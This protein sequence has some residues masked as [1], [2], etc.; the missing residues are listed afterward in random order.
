MPPVIAN[1]LRRITTWMVIYGAVKAFFWWGIAAYAWWKYRRWGRV[2][3]VL[4]ASD[5]GLILS[6]PGWRR[7]SERRWSIREIK[8]IELHPVWGNLKWKRTVADLY[9][10][11]HRGRRLR[12]RLSSPDPHLPSRIANQLKLK[13]GCPII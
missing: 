5:E 13:L 6:R 10:Q 1:E 4:T 9:I 3:R 8:A 2:P 11:R 7:I 12:F